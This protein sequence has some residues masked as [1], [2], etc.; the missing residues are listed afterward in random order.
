[1]QQKGQDHLLGIQQ[2]G[3]FKFFVNVEALP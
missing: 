3:S 2:T 1:M